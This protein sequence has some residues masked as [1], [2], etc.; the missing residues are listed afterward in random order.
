MQMIVD[1]V[2]REKIYVV[3]N[4]NLKENFSNNVVIPPQTQE[5]KNKKKYKI[6]FLSLSLFTT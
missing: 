6:K 3:M 2:M 4:L 1:K 5:S